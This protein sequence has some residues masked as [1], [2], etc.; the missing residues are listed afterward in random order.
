[1][2]RQ[3][4]LQAM[5]LREEGVAATARN[6]LQTL[7]DHGPVP[8]W[9]TNQASPALAVELGRRG[10][11][12]P[13]VAALSDGR[14]VTGIGVGLEDDRVLVWDPAHPGAAPVELGRHDGQVTPVAVLGDGR[15]VTCGWRKAIRRHDVLIWDPAHPGAAPVELGRHD[16]QVR[17][18][19]L[20]DGR[21]R[22]RGR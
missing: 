14:V 10:S 12:V 18:A 22:S 1:V 21:L 11:P 17:V 4:C 7:A 2:L 20:H 19:V 15:V 3:L 9:T 13:A 6:R 16:G 8:M 5:E